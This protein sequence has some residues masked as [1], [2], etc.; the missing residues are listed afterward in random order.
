MQLVKISNLCGLLLKRLY[1]FW[2]T[3]KNVITCAMT[4]AQHSAAFTPHR[5]KLWQPQ[6]ENVAQQLLFRITD[7]KTYDESNQHTIEARK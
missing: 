6:G 7:A 2:A 5:F 4:C 1:N 3:P